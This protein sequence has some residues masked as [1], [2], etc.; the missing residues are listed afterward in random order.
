[1]NMTTPDY[2]ERLAQEFKKSKEGID[3]LTKRQNEMKAELVKAIQENGYEDDK[4]HLWYQ[5]GSMELKYERRVSRSLNSEAAEQWA[6]ELGIWDDLKETV[7]RLDEDKLLGYA[8]NHK[9]VEDT[10]QGFYV[11]KESWAFKA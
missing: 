11:E 4:G 2:Y 8:W 1:M 5:A 7:E 6:R 3:A 10:I 9:E